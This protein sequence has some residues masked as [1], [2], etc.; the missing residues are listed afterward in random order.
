MIIPNIFHYNDHTSF[1]KEFIDVNKKNNTKYS[2]RFLAKKLNWPVSLLSDVIAER[3]GLTVVRCIE[4]ARFLSLDDLETEHLIYLSLQNNSNQMVQNHF[5]TLIQKR[6]TKN[7]IRSDIPSDEF[8]AIDR[9]AVYDYLNFTKKCP[10]FD[11]LKD[12]LFTF[13]LTRERV[14]EIISHLEKSKMIT[15]DKNQNVEV[16]QGPFFKDDIGQKTDSTGMPI[17]RNYS[18]NLQSFLEKPSRPFTLNSG[19]LVINDDQYQELLKRILNF[20]NWLF[21]NDL[22]QKDLKSKKKTKLYQ[23]DIN[24]F[25]ISHPLQGDSSL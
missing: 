11:Q 4:L 9:L 3:K 12:I 23:F 24:F 13:D 5:Q 15:I 7:E 1:L 2:H 25:P 19:F 21:E 18:E 14:E 6:S 10:D 16:L 20:R 22:T 8:I 17:H